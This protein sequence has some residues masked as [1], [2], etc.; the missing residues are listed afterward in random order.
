VVYRLQRR[1]GIDIHPSIAFVALRVTLLMNSFRH[2]SSK[3]PG[4]TST[5]AIVDAIRSYRQLARSF[6]AI[7]DWSLTIVLVV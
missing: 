7:T 2:D 6:V 1:Q 3:A 4:S 5:A